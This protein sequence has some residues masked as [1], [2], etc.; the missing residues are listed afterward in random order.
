MHKLLRTK[1]GEDH[2]DT[3]KSMFSLAFA[4]TEC[5]EKVKVRELIN[6]IEKLREQ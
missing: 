1:L 4:Y 2:P 6:Q 3:L 5:G